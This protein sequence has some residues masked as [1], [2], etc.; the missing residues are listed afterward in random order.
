MKGCCVSF[1]I[2]E[3]LEISI[4][5]KILSEVSTAKCDLLQQ[6]LAETPSDKKDSEGFNRRFAKRWCLSTHPLPNSSLVSFSSLMLSR[7]RPLVRTRLYST[8]PVT[9]Q[10]KI[11][12]KRVQVPTGLFI[13]GEWVS[14]LIS[15]SH[16]SL[17]ESY[18]RRLLEPG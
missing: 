1:L 8:M 10:I 5:L 9:Q 6:C 12:S 17:T 14:F 15:R 16:L 18:R 4:A 7:F 3:F 11:G 13:N 2:L